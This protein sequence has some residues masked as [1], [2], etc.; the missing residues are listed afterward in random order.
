[1]NKEGREGSVPRTSSRLRPRMR[2]PCRWR[3]QGGM[4]RRCTMLT[5]AAD[6]MG[7]RPASMGRTV[8]SASST[9]R[10]HVYASQAL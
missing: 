8:E 7:P 5:I 6:S 2:A 9:V 4:A 1:M 3:L 10:M